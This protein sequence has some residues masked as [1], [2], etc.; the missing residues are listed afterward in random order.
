MTV[1]CADSSALVKRYV[2]E[3]GSVWTTPISTC[4]QATHPTLLIGIAITVRNRGMAAA[5]AF[6][7]TVYS[8][9]T[10][11]DTNPIMFT[12]TVAS[13]AVD[14]QITVNGLIT[15]QPANLHTVV[16]PERALPELD[17]SNNVALA[18]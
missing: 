8:G 4:K 11:T 12:T 3:I 7:V 17:E 6:T 15:G 14:G 2:N 16:D 9:A 13:L 18:R 1:Y 10:I 5:G